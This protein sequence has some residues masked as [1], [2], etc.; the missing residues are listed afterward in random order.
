MK[1]NK[2]MTYEEIARIYDIT[3]AKAHSIAK[4]AY[5]KMIKAFIENHGINIF[6]TAGKALQGPA[7][8]PLQVYTTAVSGT[9]LTINK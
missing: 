4:T 2:K 5:N 9:T 7:T 6:D 1:P 3:P 8:Q